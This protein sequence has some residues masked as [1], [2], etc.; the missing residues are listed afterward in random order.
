MSQLPPFVSVIIPALNE[1]KYITQCLTSILN[2]SYPI[3]HVEI[4]VVDG[5]SRDQT[6]RLAMA[7]GAKVITLKGATVAAMRNEGAQKATGTILAFI[8]ADCIAHREWLAEGVRSLAQEACITGSFHDI[9]ADGSWVEKAWFVTRQKGRVPSSHINTSNLFVT[10]ELFENL[11]GF[12]QKLITGEDTEFSARAKKQVAVISDDKIQ[13]IHLAN[14][15]TIAEFFRR[16]IWHGLGA[17]GS[18]KV[19]LMDKPLLGTLAFLL[20]SFIQILG[21]IILLFGGNSLVFQAGTAVIM[22]L[23]TGTLIY[24]RKNLRGLYH[25][26]QL[27]FLHYVYYLARTISLFFLILRIPYYHGLKE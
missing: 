18:F 27:A 25:G 26:F 21:L 20:G 14:P 6:P 15:K 3:Q 23:L 2:G 9:P 24:R 4:I 13:V 17:L 10:R 12:N 8:D 11:G 19:N 1:E 5:G 16:E 7:A 22:A